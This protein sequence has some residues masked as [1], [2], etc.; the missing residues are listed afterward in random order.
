MDS[1]FISIASLAA[2]RTLLQQ[3][4]PCLNFTVDPEDLPFWNKQKKVL[5]MNYG[6]STN[7]WEP[8][9]EASLD[10]LYGGNIHQS[11]PEPTHKIQ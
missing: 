6:S 11:Q 4:L 10:I 9:S 5:S 7:S 3:L 1:Y 8:W 2:S